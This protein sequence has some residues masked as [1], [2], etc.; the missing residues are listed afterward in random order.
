MSPPVS[1]THEPAPS[2]LDPQLHG[3]WHRGATTLGPVTLRVAYQATS[4]DAIFELVA[5]QS[6]QDSL[7]KGTGNLTD[8]IHAHLASTT[9]TI[10][11]RLYLD[12]QHTLRYAYELT[13][14][15]TGQLRCAEGTITSE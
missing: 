11:L 14:T 4:T 2:G 7:L 12:D 8:G 9:G 1:D 6:D 5:N 15:S 13:S 10:N 3:P